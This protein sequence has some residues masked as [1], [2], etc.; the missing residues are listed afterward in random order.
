MESYLLTFFLQQI[1]EEDIKTEIKEEPLECNMKTEEGHVSSL[2]PFTGEIHEKSSK[3]SNVSSGH[4]KEEVEV[5]EEHEDEEKSSES[6][7]KTRTKTG[8]ITP[9]QFA[10]DDLRRRLPVEEKDKDSSKK[11]SDDA[12]VHKLTQSKLAQLQ[13]NGGFFRVST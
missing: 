11:S 2:D 6:G 12:A 8:T 5:K 4:I 13:S 1:K 9:K 3:S 10:V 7:I